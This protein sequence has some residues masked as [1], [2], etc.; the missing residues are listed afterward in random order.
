MKKYLITENQQKN[1]KEKLLTLMIHDLGV[2]NTLN[3]FNLDPRGLDIIFKDDFPDFNCDEL[4]NL[5]DYFFKKKFIKNNFTFEYKNK[6]YLVELTMEYHTGAINYVVL[7]TEQ[8]DGIS[9]YATPFFEGECWVPV[10]TAAYVL[11]SDNNNDDDYDYDFH[12]VEPTYLQIPINTKTA[13]NSFSGFVNWYETKC[14]KDIFDIAIPELE[15]L[16]EDYGS[17]YL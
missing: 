13:F 6:D 2:S 11:I 12:E 17:G 8:M 9:F 3:R 14:M 16:R 10:E 5:L 7:D 15:N 4:D 1:L